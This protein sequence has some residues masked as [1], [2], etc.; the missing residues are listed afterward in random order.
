MND[1][2]QMAMVQAVEHDGD[3]DGR[4]FHSAHFSDAFL[5]LADAKAP[6]LDS[7]IVAAVLCGRNDVVRLPG[8]DHYRLVMDE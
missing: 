7:K 5:R 3:R 2:I 1:L 8:G 6:P 4:V